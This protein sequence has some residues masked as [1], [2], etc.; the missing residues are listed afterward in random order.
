MKRFLAV[1]MRVVCVWTWPG[2]YRRHIDKI[3]TSGYLGQPSPALR[4]F[5][6]QLFR[7][8]AFIWVGR[9]RIIGERTVQLPERLIF[10]PNHSSLLDAVVMFSSMKRPVRAMGAYETLRAGGGLVGIFLT[11]IGVFPVDRAHGSTVIGPATDLVVAGESLCMFPEGRISPTGE[12]LPFKLG[13]AVIGMCADDRLGRRERIGY[14][15]V[16][17]CYHRRHNETALNFW[18]M[19]FRW[20]AGATI[21]ICE[22]IWLDQ[23]AGRNPQKVMDLIRDSIAAC[24][25]PTLPG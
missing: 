9:V 23:I 14:V 3:T 10:C 18:K 5:A 22:P 13:A 15:P 7:V 1:L 16:Q 2:A 11:K 4:S 25:C 24:G 19:G 6:R 17:I 21:T 8:L 20:R 12:L